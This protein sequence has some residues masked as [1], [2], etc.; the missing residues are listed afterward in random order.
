MSQVGLAM[1]LKPGCYEEYKR[2]HDELWPEMV[3]A[4]TSRGVD[5]VI[6]RFG[7]LLFVHGSAPNAG[8]WDEMA[9]DPVTPRWNAY[10]AEVLKT[11]EEGE[12]IFHDLPQAF[13]FGGFLY[14]D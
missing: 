1:T 8:A 4:M 14:E 7:D 9:S 6:Y 13:V 2:R 11:N 10:M 12:V 3:E 5:L